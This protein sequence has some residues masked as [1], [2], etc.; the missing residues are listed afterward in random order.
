MRLVNAD[1]LLRKCEETPWFD[2]R[3]RD[4]VAEELILSAPVIDAEPVV[5]CKRCVSARRMLGVDP[6]RTVICRLSQPDRYVSGNGFC[7]EG[8]QRAGEIP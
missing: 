3:D 7:S 5:R 8:K 1:D 6:E 4:D 2:N